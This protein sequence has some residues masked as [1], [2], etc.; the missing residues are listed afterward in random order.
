MVKRI[1][2]IIAIAMIAF[3][4]LAL[5]GDNATITV[6]ASVTGTCKLGLG[7]IPDISFGALDPSSPGNVEKTVNY[8]YWCTKGV[9]AST[10]VE[11]GDYFIG[12]SR[13]MFDGTSDYIK[14][15]LE[16]TGGDQTGSGPQTALNA[17]IKG[18]IA[19]ADWVNAT[20]GSYSD[21]VLI[22]IEP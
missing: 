8:S 6:S 13:N 10:T 5:A 15:N 2:L 19:S 14:Y 18:T 17:S 16:L 20:V 1:I 4:G 11:N 21:K 9:K 7:G 3:S 22:T 12:G